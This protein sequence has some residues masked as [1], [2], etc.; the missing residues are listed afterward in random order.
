MNKARLMRQRLLAIT[1]YRSRPD[2]AGAQRRIGRR[3]SPAP[4]STANVNISSRLHTRQSNAVEI[5]QRL[6]CKQP[7]VDV[8]LG[9][10]TFFSS[11]LLRSFSNENNW[12]HA[13]L[14][15]VAAQHITLV[16]PPRYAK[17]QV[18]RLG[19]NK[20]VAW[21]AAV[22]LSLYS[23]SR[24]YRRAFRSDLGDATPQRSGTRPRLTVRAKKRTGAASGPS[25]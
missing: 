20:G 9:K 22:S 18:A 8:A 4:L 14:C 12:L 17:K 1:Q 11:R 2:W 23:R 10:L 25:E 24:R 15:M 16:S 19:M 5:R 21:L 7:K 3:A 6:I 13:A